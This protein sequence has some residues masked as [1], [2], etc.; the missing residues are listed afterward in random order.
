M[1]GVTEVLYNIMRFPCVCAESAEYE[2]EKKKRN[3]YAL[4]DADRGI[5]EGYPTKITRTERSQEMANEAQLG[6]LAVKDV[7]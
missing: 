3:L 2:K 5:N 7:T 6:H 1:N 4:E